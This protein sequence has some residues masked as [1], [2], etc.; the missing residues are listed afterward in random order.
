MVPLSSFIFPVE[1]YMWS[2]GLAVPQFQKFIL[3]GFQAM[4]F[5]TGEMYSNQYGTVRSCMSLVAGLV[6]KR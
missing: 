5:P 4:L 3:G 1:L 6:P 2:F